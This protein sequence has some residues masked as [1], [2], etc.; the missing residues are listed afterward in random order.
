MITNILCSRNMWSILERVNDLPV[1]D[2]SYNLSTLVGNFLNLDTPPD[3]NEVHVVLKKNQFCQSKCNAGICKTVSNQASH[4]T[5][6]VSKCP[7]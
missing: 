5:L 1:L 3:S 6:L 2:V 4:L 7:I